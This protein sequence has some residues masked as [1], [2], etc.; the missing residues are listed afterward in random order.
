MVSP[1]PNLRF[2]GL[3]QVAT[4]WCPVFFEGPSGTPDLQLLPHKTQVSHGSHIIPATLLHTC[5]AAQGISKGQKL[6]SDQLSTQFWGGVALAKG[7]ALPQQL[8]HSLHL[9]KT[10]QKKT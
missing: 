1:D 10:G 4:S 8:S 2:M 6:Q 3:D 9:H 7:K 5:A